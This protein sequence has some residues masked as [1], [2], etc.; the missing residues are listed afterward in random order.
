MC[1]QRK[2]RRIACID[3]DSFIDVHHVDVRSLRSFIS[4][5]VFFSFYIGKEDEFFTMKSNKKKKNSSAGVVTL[6]YLH[7]LDIDRIFE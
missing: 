5:E 6:F 2:A 4:S 1:C 3:I 7:R